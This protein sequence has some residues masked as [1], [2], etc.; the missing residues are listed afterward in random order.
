MSLPEKNDYDSLGGEKTDYSPVADPST[1]LSAEELN[2]T[3]ADVAAMTQTAIRAWCAFT[4]DGYASP[5]IGDTEQD[6]GAVY[7]RSSSY[8][9]SVSRV[10]AGEYTI[11]FP[12]SVV[13]AR[14]NTKSLNI[15]CGFGNSETMEEL[16]NVKRAS[17]N[18]LT[19]YI[20]DTTDGSRRD[21]N[22]KIIVFIL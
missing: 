18:T 10:T 14:G 13:D 17:A 2:E 20:W 22:G 9:P 8:K 1:D 3:R 5:S 6:Y 4:V 12:T 11:T 19:V 15:Q 16:V 21:P 7:G